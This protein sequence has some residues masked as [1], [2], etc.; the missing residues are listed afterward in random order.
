MPNDFDRIFKENFE[1][2]LPYLLRKVLGLEFPRLEDLKDKIQV[3]IERELDDLKKVVHDDP[4][5]DY[6]LHWE[7]QSADDDMRHRNLLY[8]ALFLQK[9]NLPLKQ[10]VIYV[11][12]EKPKRV[13][14]TLLELEGL[15][16]EFQV[17]NLREI[18]KDTFLHSDVPEEA[19]LAILSDF[20]L[21]QPEKVIRQ[22]LQHLL[23]LI[24]RVP[25]LK[26]YQYQLQT[27]SRLRKLEAQTKKEI[28][29][30]PIHY[31]LETDALYL[32]GKEIGLEQ[33]IEKHK[34]ESVV[35]MLRQGQLAKE[36]IALYA[37][38]DITFVLRV[39]REI[40][41]SGKNE[42]C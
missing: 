31:E 14:Q 8:Y 36:V 28:L 26:K 30:M 21:E 29:A 17:V 23:K 38:V 10:I 25:R 3:T 15:R 24:G 32:E 27:L 12:N 22:I 18:P 34:Y 40:Q 4:R 11:G 2:L 13:L 35:R 41:E 37:G 6:G 42:Q 16:L 9:Y 1:P 39:E 5:L 20:G 7:I 33:G 19:V